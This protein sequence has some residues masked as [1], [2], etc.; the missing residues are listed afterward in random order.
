MP[1]RRMAVEVKPSPSRCKNREPIQRSRSSSSQVSTSRSIASAV[2]LAVAIELDDIVV[3]L[4]GGGEQVPGLDRRTDAAVQGQVDDVHPQAAGLGQFVS[5]LRG[6]VGRAVVHQQDLEIGG[7]RFEADDRI[8]QRRRFVE[9][10]DDDQVSGGLAHGV[11]FVANRA[12]VGEMKIG[13]SSYFGWWRLQGNR[14][15][16]PRCE[17]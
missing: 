5:D 17:F 6:Q 2:V 8:G 11:R 15:D 4:A 3:L 10:W 12:A 9:G 13:N 14:R 7:Q 16:T 1:T